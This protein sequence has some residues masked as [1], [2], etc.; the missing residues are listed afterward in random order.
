[1]VDEKTVKE[2]TV[3]ASRKKDGKKAPVKSKLQ[4]VLARLKSKLLY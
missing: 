2:K 1:M 4:K 3:K